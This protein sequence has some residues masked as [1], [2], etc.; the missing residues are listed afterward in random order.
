MGKNQEE[1]IRWTLVKAEEYL[2]SANENLKKNRL[3]PAAE[4]IFRTI[5]TTLEA[6]VYNYGVKEITYP[7]KKKEFTGRLAL[8]FLIRDN[9][10]KTKRVE[11]DAY[12][13]YMELASNL[14]LG[15]YQKMMKFDKKI[16]NKDLRFAEDFLIK[17]KSIVNATFQKTK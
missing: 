5:E 10:I 6:L 13:K 9:L 2:D 16:L 4:E 14:H 3:F 11:N 1:L 7:G 15:G 17:G 12:K 8:Q